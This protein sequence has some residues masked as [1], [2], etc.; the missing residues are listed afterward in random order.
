MLNKFKLFL[1]ALG[2]ISLFANTSFAEDDFDFDE[3]YVEEIAEDDDVFGEDINDVEEDTKSEAEIGDAISAK[4]IEN[5]D[6]NGSL[7]QQI[8]ELEQE[9]ILMQLEKERAQLNLE[10]DK[11][12]AEK[13][14]LNMEIENLSGRAEQQQQELITERAR[15]EAE[16]QR[17]EAQKEALEKNEETKQTE[18]KQATVSSSKDVEFSKKYKLVNVMGA[19]SQ[20]QATVQDS[21]SGQNKKLSVG[22]QLDGYTVKSISLDEGVVFQKGKE[23]ETLNI[24]N[25]R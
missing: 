12:A 4:S 14:K 24:E 5:Y 6:V 19:G 3:D 17:L 9:K 25:K 22:K 1:I 2:T 16:A 7:F 10:L 8:T 21:V 20:L 15:L 18:T 13:I 23:I 11:L